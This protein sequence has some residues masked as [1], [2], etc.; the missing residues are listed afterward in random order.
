MMKIAHRGAYG[1]NTIDGILAAL[2]AGVGAEFDVRDSGGELLIAHDA[3]CA[4]GLFRPVDE[5]IDRVENLPATL[6]TPLAVNIKANGLAKQLAILF[7]RVRIPFFF[8]DVNPVEID[9]YLEYRLPVFLRY[10]EREPLLTHYVPRAAGVLIDE[11]GDESVY[12]GDV[13]L[14][15]K[16]R[17][18]QEGSP[19]LKICRIGRDLRGYDENWDPAYDC[20]Y[21]ITKNFT[22][23]M[24]G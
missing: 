3:F 5:L 15:W 14:F 17:E 18:L 9:S 6:K 10:S 2:S 1:D 19:H 23:G 8:F 16:I 20:D 24:K 11:Y 4:R 13:R 22:D 7:S 21:V 12:P